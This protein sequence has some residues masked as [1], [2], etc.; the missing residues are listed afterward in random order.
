VAN[1]LR[2]DGRFPLMNSLLNEHGLLEK[3]YSSLCAP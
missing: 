2:E 3:D 1:T